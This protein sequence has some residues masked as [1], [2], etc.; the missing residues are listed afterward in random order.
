M[1]KLK[2]SFVFFAIISLT[3]S[4]VEKSE[5]YKLAVAQRDSLYVSEQNLK[6]EYDEVINMVEEIESKFQ[7]IREV[8][9]QVLIQIDN[10][11]TNN[12][13]KKE[14]LSSQ[15]IMIQEILEENKNK[16][17]QLENKLS[18]SNKKIAALNKTVARLQ[19][20]L[21]KKSV[22][23]EALQGELSKKDIKIKELNESITCLND[24]NNNLRQLA[25]SQQEAL[26]EQ[27]NEIHTV[28]YVVGDSKKLKELDI[29][30]T[31]GIFKPTTLKD[32]EFDKSKFNQVDLRNLR[33][34]DVNCKNPKLLSVHPKTSY[35]LAM[36]EEIG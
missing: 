21:S 1:N 15:I 30:K 24:N 22:L 27:D 11:E 23:V 8:E 35:R 16:I 28:W 20:E 6:S 36:K 26:E 3:T 2:L 7:S 33:T 34:V 18:G 10:G 17:E 5:K 12:K 29:I 25:T 14:I 13:T 9:N 19:E 31:N 32:E 4:C